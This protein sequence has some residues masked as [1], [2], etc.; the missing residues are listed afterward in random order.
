MNIFPRTSAFF[1][2]LLC[3][4]LL[5]AQHLHLSATVGR[6]WSAQSQALGLQVVQGQVSYLNQTFGEGMIYGGA[7]TFMIND[8]VGITSSLQYHYGFHVYTRNEAGDTSMFQV[9]DRAQAK[10][11]V[12]SIG[13]G[14]VMKGNMGP[15]SPYLRWEGMYAFSGQ[16]VEQ[17]FLAVPWGVSIATQSTV[18]EFVEKPTWGIR[19]AIGLDRRLTQR[20]GI[21]MEAKGE[22]LRMTPST[23]EFTTV[24][25]DGI[26]IRDRLGT[27]DLQTVYKD[28][29]LDYAQTDPNAPSEQLAFSRSF[30]H[31]ALNVGL[32]VQLF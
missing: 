8:Q 5:P 26:D 30:S 12:W 16:T 28:Q 15:V 31:I 4:S 19:G 9:S 10:S 32:R 3:I 29:V 6:A 7:A 11:D 18:E 24:K 22:F 27:S 25:R 1:G 20:I 2:F 21:F 13:I 17:R 14:M 23:S